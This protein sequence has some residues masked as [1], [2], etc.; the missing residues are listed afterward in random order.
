MFFLTFFITS[1]FHESVAVKHAPVGGVR[2]V[3]VAIV[4]SSPSNTAPVRGN[5]APA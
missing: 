1:R 5:T 3:W 2:G 4:L